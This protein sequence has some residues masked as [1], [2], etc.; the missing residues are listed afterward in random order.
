LAYRSGIETTKGGK[1]EEKHA[2][3]R[4]KY[5]PISQKVANNWGIPT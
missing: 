4:E 3:E 5:V 1:Y 2:S